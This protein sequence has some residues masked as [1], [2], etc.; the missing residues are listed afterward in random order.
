MSVFDR[1]FGSKK[2]P[3]AAD[4]ERA[5]LKAAR[6][7]HLAKLRDLLEAATDVNSR[8]KS[9]QTALHRG[10]EVMPETLRVQIVS[11]LLEF[12]ANVNLPDANGVTPLMLACWF[13]S[14][15]IAETLLQAG[16]DPSARLVKSITQ[17]WKNSCT[18]NPQSWALLPRSTPLM[19]A[20]S[21]VRPR[22][23]ELLLK[24]GADPN[25]SR[26]SQAHQTA[27]HI[28]ECCG[29]TPGGERHRDGEEIKRLLS[30]A[31]SKGRTPTP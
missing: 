8:D 10:F 18:L 16:A 3:T 22:T 24:W 15:G 31:M 2:P 13:G 4:N 26:G 5:L 19:M 14:T 29:W 30:K 23:V 25:A 17:E 28:A 7:G 12:G 20:T 9:A 6:T 1:L 21:Q 11:L 27:L